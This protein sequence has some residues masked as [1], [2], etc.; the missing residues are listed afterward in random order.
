MLMLIAC[1]AG[2]DTAATHTDEGF[3]TPEERAVVESLAPMGPVP[4]DATNAV[5]DDPD[6]VALGQWLYFDPALSV[7][8]SVSCATCHDP[9]R[10]FSD[11]MALSQGTGQ[12]L[13][14]APSL[15]NGA[16]NRWFYWDG[17]CDTMWCQALKPIEH[18][19]E[20]GSSRL[21]L[22][23]Q[24]RD[25][26]TLRQAYE[27]LFGAMP[28]LSDVTR[29]PREGRPVPED[30]SDPLNIAWDSMGLKDQ[31]AIS[32]VFARV[33]KAIAAYERVL[34]TGDAPLDAYVALLS[35]EGEDAARA[36]GILSESA[37]RGLKL[38]AGDAG[39][40]FCH[41]GPNLTNGEFHNLGLE[42]QDWLQD[43]DPGRYAGIAIL[44]EDPFRGTGPYSDDPVGAALKLEHLV[45]GPDQLGQFKV[46]T[47]RNVAQSPP[48]MHGGQ[49]ET[50]ADVVRFYNELDQEVTV[51]HREELLVPLLLDEQD[52]A[53]IVAFLEALTGPGPDAAL[54]AAPDSP[55]Q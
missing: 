52:V 41:S 3:Y 30:P 51:G 53:D 4:T 11:G 37:E 12:T 34:L 55:L 49:L 9:A 19:D 40:H 43:D 23:H 50:L 21:A 8:G 7:D 18:P 44:L 16:Y 13:R 2:S 27:N 45:N 42:N 36:S 35:E 32:Q 38:F 22:A 46:P 28:D 25:D 14:H 6:A 29:F 31:E 47:L 24:I 1:T 33:G 10:G 54:L 48:F 39:C 5:G 20:M 15:W 26:D 17:R